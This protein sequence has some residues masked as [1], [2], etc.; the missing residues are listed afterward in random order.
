MP[1]GDLPELAGLSE[2]LQHRGGGFIGGLYGRTKHR[3]NNKLAIN[4]PSSHLRFVA[5]VL[6]VQYPI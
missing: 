5:S 1:C 4:L 6:A 3:I 2:L